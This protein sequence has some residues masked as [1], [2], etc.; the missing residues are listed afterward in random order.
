MVRPLQK[1]PGGSGKKS[2]NRPMTPEVFPQ[3][4]AAENCRQQRSQSP[5]GGDSPGVHRRVMNS[6]VRP[7]TGMLPGRK[8]ARSPEPA[9]AQATPQ[10]ATPSELAGHRSETVGF[11]FHETLQAGKITETESGR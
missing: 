7:H 6:V 11:H 4:K 9:A 2:E 5:A 10:N 1:R 3:G 8:Q